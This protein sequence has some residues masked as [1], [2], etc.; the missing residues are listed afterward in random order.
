MGALQLTYEPNLKIVHRT[1]EPMRSHEAKS[2]QLWLSVDPL[3]EKYPNMSPYIYCHNNPINMI[4]P[5]GRDAILI[6]F[7]NYK[8]ET[9]VRVTIKNPFTGKPIV[10]WKAPKVGLGHAGVL[11]I[12]NKT[13]V[14]SYYEYGRYDKEQ[15]GI[16]RKVSVSN[17]VIGEDGKPTQESLDKVLGQISAKSGQGGKIEGA[18]I[19]SDKAKEMK[20][21]AEKVMGQNT[22]EK[23]DP[24]TLT[25]NNCATFA[26]DVVNQDPKVSQ[27]SITNPT[28]GN[29][30]NEYQEEGN[31]RV[32]FDPKTKKGNIEKQD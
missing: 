27:P 12:D 25:G 6:A 29:V 24:Y 5:D 26:A 14:T 32:T 16:V 1:G 22:D 23:R 8:V 19:E 15:K 17:V 10:N 28:P 9:G 31:A 7:P 4:D 20:A 21:Y 13:G 3:A 11:I 2:V 18:Y 30:V